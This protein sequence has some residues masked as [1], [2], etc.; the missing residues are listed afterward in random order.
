M[1]KISFETTSYNFDPQ[2]Q[3][4]FTLL[5]SFSVFLSQM[6]ERCQPGPKSTVILLRGTA[7]SP[8]VQEAQAVYLWPQKAETECQCRNKTRIHFSSVPRDCRSLRKTSL[9]RGD[10][11]PTHLQPHQTRVSRKHSC[12]LY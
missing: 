8:V 2:P 3:L 10:P 6:K 11:E 4:S 5:S 1:E 7:I 9:G 12:C